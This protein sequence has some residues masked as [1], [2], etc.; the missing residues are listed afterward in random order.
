M[1]DKIHVS[2]IQRLIKADILSIDQAAIV[3]NISPNGVYQRLWRMKRGLL[4]GK[5]TEYLRPA[6]VERLRGFLMDFEQF[7]SKHIEGLESEE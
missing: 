7:I 5:R 3:L 4:K 6:E 1:N 2:E